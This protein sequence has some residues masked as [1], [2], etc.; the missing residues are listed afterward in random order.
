MKKQELIDLSE[1]QRLLLD[2]LMDVIIGKNDLLTLVSGRWRVKDIMAHI[3]WYEK[4]M[5]NLIRSMS[6]IGS[7]YW[8]LP[9]HER[10][11][12]IFQEYYEFSAEQIINEY[13]S[14]FRP[15]M[16]QVNEL[17]ENSMTNASVFD[18]M[19]LEWQPWELFAGNM[20]KHYEDHILQLQ[21]RFEYITGEN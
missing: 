20:F 4:E 8:L 21:K 9:T 2:Q 3:F 19:P 5:E 10:N 17:T 7:E 6:L 14:S 11:E 12:K 16:D 18:K 1:Q 15:M 13:Q